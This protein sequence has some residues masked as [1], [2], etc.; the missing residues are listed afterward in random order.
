[1]TT[2]VT[3]QGKRFKVSDPGKSKKPITDKHKG[4]AF[5]T[6]SAKDKD[7][8]LKAALKKLGMLDEEDK[9]K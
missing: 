8:L 2:T 4:K 6:L 9:I 5:D 1:M 3:Q 7:E